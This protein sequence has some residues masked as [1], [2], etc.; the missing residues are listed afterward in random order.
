MKSMKDSFF[1]LFD[2]SGFLVT[3][4]L[5]RIILPCLFASFNLVQNI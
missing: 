3:F 5:D 2:T 4:I 1:P